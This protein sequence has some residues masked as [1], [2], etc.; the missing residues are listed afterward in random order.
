MLKR[1]KLNIKKSKIHGWGVFSDE[2][3][4]PANTIIGEYPIIILTK[5]DFNTQRYAFYWNKKIAIALGDVS[6]I[7]HSI[8]PNCDWENDYTKNLIILKSI[9][10][11]RKNEELSINYREL[12]V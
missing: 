1:L 3:Y 8:E 9:K 6:L 2:D 10:D 7:N 4:I 12:K 5:V 11:I